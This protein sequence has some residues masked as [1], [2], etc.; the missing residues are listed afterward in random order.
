MYRAWKAWCAEDVSCTACYVLCETRLLPTAA[1]PADGGWGLWGPGE[2]SS[3][4]G[5]N[6]N[7]ATATS[8]YTPDASGAHVWQ[9]YSCDEPQAFLCR[10][11]GER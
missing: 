9:Q 4:G 2:P 7:C 6:E 1:A 8:D 11:V 5:T 10:M 3:K